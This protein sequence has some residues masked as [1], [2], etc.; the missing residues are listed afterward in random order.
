[1]QSIANS[2]TYAQNQYD[3]ISKTQQIYFIKQHDVKRELG[4]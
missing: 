3:E 1:M 2:F 4:E